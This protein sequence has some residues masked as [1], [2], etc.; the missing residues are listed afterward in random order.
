MVRRFFLW[1]V[2]NLFER[3]GDRQFMI[4]IVVMVIGWIVAPRRAWIVSVIALSI[5]AM[6]LTYS[7]ARATNSAPL[8]SA[9]VRAVL[10]E[11]SR[12]PLDMFWHIDGTTPLT[13]VL[14]L[15]GL[16]LRA[17]PALGGDWPTRRAR[18]CICCGLAGCCGS[19]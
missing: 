1:Q 12:Y 10:V 14:A 4:P 2:V 6:I 8:S 13:L 19:A 16:A 18:R 5:A 9:L 7:I 15:S 11:G 17:W 3:P